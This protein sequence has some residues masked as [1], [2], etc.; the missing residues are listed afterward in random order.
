MYPQETEVIP[1]RS[2]KSQAIKQVQSSILFTHTL[3]IIVT[4]KCCME[5]VKT[6]N[7][8]GCL[9]VFKLSNI[10]LIASTLSTLVLLFCTA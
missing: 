9:K 1:T 3:L 10:S 4:L 5:T 8:K 7:S 6:E 2:E